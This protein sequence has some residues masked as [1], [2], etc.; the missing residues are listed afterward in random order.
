[1]LS[2]RRFDLSIIIPAFNEQENLFECVNKINKC[3]GIINYE[4]IIIDD[5]SFDDTWKI[6]ENLKKQYD[7]IVIQHQT[8]AGVSVARNKGIEIAKANKIMFV[9]ADDNLVDNWAEIIS[10]YIKLDYDMI[11]MNI[12]YE[13]NIKNEMQ[14]NTISIDPSM[15]MKILLNRKRYYNSELGYSLVESTHGVYGKIYNKTIIHNNFIRFDEKATIG[16]DILFYMEILSHCKSCILV[17]KLLYIISYNPLSSTRRYNP[18]LFN[19]VSYFSKILCDKYPDEKLTDEL[20]ENKYY[21][22][23]WHVYCG[24]LYNLGKKCELNLGDKWK[25]LH[26]ILKQSEI[27]NALEY[28]HVHEKSIG[29]SKRE[30]CY[31]ELLRKNLGIIYIWMHS[32]K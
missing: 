3:Y 13:D 16:E 25:I 27:Q 8:N 32:F 4:I 18:R 10:D 15:L 23:Y 30:R 5:G 9:D 28:L 12:C 26:D 7:N 22:I 1:M 21:Q 20:V 11:Q 29:I 6:C 31:I 24:V 14:G 19:G 2:D 17:D